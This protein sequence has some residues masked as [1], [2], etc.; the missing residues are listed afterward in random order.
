M[1]AAAILKKVCQVASLYLLWVVLHFAAVQLYVYW[2][3]PQ[4]WAGWLYSPFLA[5]MPHCRLLR[6]TIYVGGHQVAALV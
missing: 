3:V 2:C 1:A 5:P 4:T 6:W